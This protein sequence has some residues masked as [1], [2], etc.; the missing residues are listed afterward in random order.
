MICCL[1][2]SPCSL[3][4]ASYTSVACRAIAFGYMYVLLELAIKLPYMFEF[5][6]GMLSKTLRNCGAR[7][8]GCGTGEVELVEPF[9]GF[10]EALAPSDLPQQRDD[11]SFATET[12]L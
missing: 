7:V 10:P 8:A 1:S 5:R 3:A 4:S 2:G 9:P 6:F 11:S 12:T